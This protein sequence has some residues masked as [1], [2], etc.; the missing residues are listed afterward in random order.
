MPVS[1]SGTVSQAKAHNIS[2][3][4]NAQ[5]GT[6]KNGTGGGALVLPD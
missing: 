3:Q 6:P 2:V 1:I 4:I 5:N